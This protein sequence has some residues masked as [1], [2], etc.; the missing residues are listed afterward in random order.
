MTGGVRAC[1]ARTSYADLP[2]AVAHLSA[3]LSPG[4]VLVLELSGPGGIDLGVLDALARLRLTAHRSAAAL[5]LRAPEPDL[6]RLAELAGLCDVLDLP[7][8]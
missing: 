8:R 7:G 3:L 2:A 1:T 4:R 6:V 5:H